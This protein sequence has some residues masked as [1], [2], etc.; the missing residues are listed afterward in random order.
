ME[1]KR[2]GGYLHRVI[3]IKDA[4]GKVID[5][6]LKPVM[7]E[8]RPRDIFQ[9]I[10]GA[11]LLAVPLSFT[12]EVWVLG[13]ELP[14]INIVLVASIS[15]I[16]IS[17]FIYFNFYRFEI[18]GN[19]WRFVM[20]VF[21][22]YTTALCVSALL[23]FLLGKLPDIAVGMKRIVLVTFPASMSATLSDTIK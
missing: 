9:I 1:K 2:I 10:V 8:I 14:G 18:K 16:F 4:S 17:L 6:V 20:R 11:A 22:T 13:A 15:L 21:I 5:H 19:W 7:T 12:E 3:P 23:L